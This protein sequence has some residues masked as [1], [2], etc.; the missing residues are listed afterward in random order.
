[1]FEISVGIGIVG[2]GCVK[3]GV[4]IIGVEEKNR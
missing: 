3:R 1:M 4:V 2:S